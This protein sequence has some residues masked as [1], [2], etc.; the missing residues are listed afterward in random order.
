[1]KIKIGD[2]NF[3]RMAAFDWM[4]SPTKGTLADYLQHRFGIKMAGTSNHAYIYENVI[5]VN[6]EEWLIMLLK[7]QNTNP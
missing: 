1:M 7:R 2:Y 6:E 4:L 3:L 5:E